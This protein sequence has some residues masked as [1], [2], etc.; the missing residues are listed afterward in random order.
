MFMTVFTKSSE[1]QKKSEN[2]KPG[3]FYSMNI[4][5]D[6]LEVDDVKCLHLF[7]SKWTSLG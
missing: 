3:H 1:K 4:F 7:F 2:L 6:I 5:G